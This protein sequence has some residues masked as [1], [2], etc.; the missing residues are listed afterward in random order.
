MMIRIDR[1]D[2]ESYKMWKIKRHSLYKVHAVRTVLPHGRAKD[3]RIQVWFYVRA[4]CN[5][6]NFVGRKELIRFRSHEITPQY[7]LNT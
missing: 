3:R 5:Y 4:K 7:T 6:G 1:A 2:S